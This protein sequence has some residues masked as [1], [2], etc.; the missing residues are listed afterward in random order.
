MIEKWIDQL[1]SDCYGAG[2]TECFGDGL[3]DQMTVREAVEAIGKNARLLTKDGWIAEVEITDA[4][5]AYGQVRLGVRQN[6]SQWTDKFGK[7]IQTGYV[8]L[9]TKFVD[10]SRVEII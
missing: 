2:C 1:C 4:T 6:L 7:P 3:V 8:P 5:V 10:A 9:R